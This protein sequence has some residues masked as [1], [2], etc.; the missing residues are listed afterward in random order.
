MLRQEW[1]LI[2]LI[3][4]TATSMAPVARQSMDESLKGA[5]DAV[6]RK[7]R[8]LDPNSQEYYNDLRSYKYH[9]GEGD[10]KFDRDRQGDREIDAE[11]EEIEF[12]PNEAGQLETVG[13]GFQDLNNKL[14]ERALTDYLES[15]PEQEEPVSSFRERE[16]SSSRKRGSS[17]ERQNIDQKEL[18]KLFV[19]KLQDRS[20]YGLGDMDDE[21]YTDARQMLY[22]RYRADRDN[23]NKL[24]ESVGPMSWGELLNKESLVR[25]QGREPDENEYADRE[26]D[27]NLL[28]LSLAGRRNVNGRYPIGHD[29]RTYQ[30]MAKHYPVAKRSAKSMPPNKQVTDPKVAQDLG[31]LFGTQ[32]T[33]G[34]NHTHGHD[35]DHDHEHDHDHS[36]DIDHKHEHEHEHES[37]S[38]APKVTP[39]AKGQ[40]ENATKLGKSKSIE[41]RKKSVDLSQY[42]GID[43]RKKKSVDWSQYLGIDRRRKKSDDWSQYVGIDRRRER[44]SFM[45]N[46]GSQNQDAEWMLQRYY[47]NMGEDLRGDDREYDKENAERKEKLK[48][49][50][51]RLKNIKDLIVEEDL[52]NPDS[53]VNGNLQKAKD[54]VLARMAAQYSL[55]K[56]R[57]ALNDMRGSFAASAQSN[58]TSSFRENS[59][60]KHSDKHDVNGIIE[61]EGI[62][63]NRACPEVEAIEK[64]CIIADGLAEDESQ[65]LY[66]PCIMLQVC[67]ACLQDDLGCL[68]NYGLETSKICDAREMQE[69]KRVKEACVVAALVLSQLQPPAAVALQC[70]FNSESCLRRYHYRYHRRY[71]RCRNSERRLNGGQSMVSFQRLDRY[72]KKGRRAEWRS[73]TSSRRI[74][75]PLLGITRISD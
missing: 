55:E 69:G 63:E 3:V 49:V 68:Y 75:H 15:V 72:K 25:G 47:E 73:K 7:Q 24:Y 42:V 56:M 60:V 9:G 37:T 46:P 48:Q 58:Q 67:K 34:R 19:E 50:V 43:R 45:A 65:I 14:L 40:E 6:T 10:R 32:S 21:M 30:N 23:N 74:G 44:T 53:E 62:D 12:L 1:L 38:E 31:A 71:L 57:K 59:P 5:L 41:V 64:R 39:P 22:D 36:R 35:H 4:G 26:Q 61:N 2:L 13:N 11:D 17:S 16:R 8:S 66:L 18:A 52:K 70:R 28:Y 29:L 20:P 51:A 33:D 27:P 54:K